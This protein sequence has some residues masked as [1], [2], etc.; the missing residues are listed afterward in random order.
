MVLLVWVKQG[1][2]DWY[3]DLDFKN[4]NKWENYVKSKNKNVFFPWKKAEN[5]CSLVPVEAPKGSF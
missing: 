1:G 3:E 2:H 5:S 4:E